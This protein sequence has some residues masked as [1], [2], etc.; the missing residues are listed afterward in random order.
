[1]N[2]LEKALG[3]IEL[4]PAEKI[5]KE[6]T[7]YMLKLVPKINQTEEML[8]YVC[9]KDGLSL[10][11]ASKRLITPKLCEVAVNQ[12]GLALEYVPDKIIKGKGKEWHAALCE[13]A[14]KNNGFALKYV[15]DELKNANIIETAILNCELATER[16]IE[17]TKFPIAYAPISLLTVELLMKA[18]EHTPLC[19]KDIPKKKITKAI[20]IAAVKGNGLALQYVPNRFVNEEIIS[21]AIANNEMAVRFVPINYLNQTVCDE[22]FERNP[23]VLAYLPLEYVS[24]EMCLKTIEQRKFSVFRFSEETMIELFGNE[25]V[26]IVLFDDIPEK[27]RNDKDILSAIVKLYKYGSLPLIKWNERVVERK[28]EGYI[29]RRDK[30]NVEINPLRKKTVDF[31][32][33]KYVEPEEEKKGE[34]SSVRLALDENRLLFTQEIELPLQTDIPSSY[35]IIPQVEGSLIAHD[36]SEN[37]IATRRIY[38]ITDIH[39]EHQMSALIKE[40]EKQPSELQEQAILDFIKE[41]ISEMVSDINDRDD[42]LLIGGDVADSVQLS[43]LFYQELC[44][45]WRGGRVISVLGNHELWDGTSQKDWNNPH[46]QSRAIEEIVE[47]YKSNIHSKLFFNS[48]L[49]ENELF[50]HFK[51]KDSRT[52]TGDEILNAPNSDLEDL[53]SKCTLIVLGG[54]GYSGLNPIYNSDMGLYRKTITSIEEDKERALRFKKIYDKV[55]ECAKNRRVIVLTHTPVYDWTNDSCNPNWIYVNGHTHQNS[56]TISEDGTTV[57]SDNQIGYKPSKWKLHSFTIDAQWYDPFEKYKDGIYEITSDEY[58]EFNRGRGILCNGCSYAGKL[59]M[60]KRDNMYMFV[61]ETARSL[62]LMVGGQRK[63]LPNRN[64][65]YYYDNLQRYSESIKRIIAPY[66]KVMKQ[67]SEEVKRIGGSGNIHGCIVD[68]S[69]FSH[70]YVNPFDGKITPYWALDMMSRK[71]YANVQKLLEKE[72]PNLLSDY[73][74]ASKK[75]AIPLIGKQALNADSGTEIATIPKWV[76]GTEMYQPSRIM[77]A[78]QFVWEQNVIRIWNDDVLKADNANEPLMIE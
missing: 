53:L 13:K 41:R 71:P 49:L 72:E 9:E 67:L 54:I 24:K 31:L 50:I 78:I 21:M 18:V 12:N 19:I 20:S 45:Q 5:Y 16:V 59:Y 15:P 66:Q 3:L 42:M 62:C 61:L 70:I 11:H 35:S 27:L 29:A 22:C 26:G 7:A 74:I 39:I 6:P 55:M 64:I 75:K 65:H 57:L 68:I 30:R 28:K 2:Q 25:N 34:E 44:R 10:K 40:I 77:K 8:M 14:V 63:S 47:D 4:T 52:L 69:F 48:I 43:S 1:M 73:R 23:A 32:L 51:D 76:F 60:I 37:E 33:T 36:F 56:L 58:R 17:W 46:F 38:Y